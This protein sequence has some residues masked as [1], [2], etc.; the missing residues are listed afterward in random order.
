MSKVE[1]EWE[2]NPEAEE[3]D[4]LLHVTYDPRK[5]TVAQ[6]LDRVQEEEFEAEIWTDEGA[7]INHGDTEARSGGQ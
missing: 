4:D 5:I 7:G 2:R 6:M 3:V 1:D